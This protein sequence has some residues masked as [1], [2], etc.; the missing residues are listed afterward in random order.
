MP[1][2]L[3]VARTRKESL[4]ARKR[5]FPLTAVGFLLVAIVTWIGVN[6]SALRE[7]IR[8]YEARTRE[9]ERIDELQQRLRILTK[10]QRGL[11]YNG[12]EVERRARERLGLHKPGEQVIYLKPSSVESTIT[13]ETTAS[14]ALL[15]EQ[16][17]VPPQTPAPTLRDSATTPSRARTG[18]KNPPAD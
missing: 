12:F 10:Q 15:A 13:L 17:T 16:N 9:Q 8:V 7:Y 14:A 5:F 18:R 1:G 6:A 2:T 3:K 11:K 4:L